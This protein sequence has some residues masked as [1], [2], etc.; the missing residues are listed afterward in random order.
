MLLSLNKRM[1]QISS[2]VRTLNL[3]KKSKRMSKKIQKVKRDF[4]SSHLVF[5]FFNGSYV[6]RLKLYKLE[7][8]IGFYMSISCNNCQ[9]PVPHSQIEYYF[10]DQGYPL[11]FCSDTCCSFF[12]DKN[13]Y[14]FQN[15]TIRNGCPDSAM[16]FPQYA[17]M[18][19]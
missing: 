11:V 14:T 8:T 17:M 1:D 5:P 3:T 7:N 18:M 16:F 2:D 4:S 12:S 6:C 13:P 15:A 19:Q 9:T 10:L